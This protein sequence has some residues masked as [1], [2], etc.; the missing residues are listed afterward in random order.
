MIDGNLLLTWMSHCWEG[1]WDSF[2]RGIASMTGEQLN[3]NELQKR[4]HKLRYHLSDMG[5]IQFLRQKRLRWNALPP[6]IVSIPD[7]PR[8]SVLCGARSPGLLLQVQAACTQNSVAIERTEQDSLPDWLQLSGEIEA[9]QRVARVAE[10]DYVADILT[11]SIAKIESLEQ[12]ADRAPVGK[13]IA[14]WKERFF[15]LQ[16]GRWETSSI[17]HSVVECTPIHGESIYLVQVSRKRMIR[18]PKREAVF[19]ALAMNGRKIA[20]YDRGRK[21]LIIPT[22]ASLPEHYS[23]IASIVSSGIGKV[24]NRTVE[25][26]PISE[27]NAHLLLVALGQA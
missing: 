18:M 22:F 24:S 11:E 9:I 25:Y 19:L 17:D 27:R 3:E 12:M 1:S 7:T 26:G 4:V 16:T 15:D 23:R 21:M 5:C 8:V 13:R 2:R 14:G 20:Q 6:C 10:V